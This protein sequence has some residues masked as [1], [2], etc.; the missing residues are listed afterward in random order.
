MWVEL[1]NLLILWLQCWLD[2]QAQ[3]SKFTHDRLFLLK[4]GSLLPKNLKIYSQKW[5]FTPKNLKI[6]SGARWDFHPKQANLTPL[7]LSSQ[8]YSKSGSLLRSHPPKNQKIYSGAGWNFHPKRANLTPLHLVPSLEK[9]LSKHSQF[10]QNSFE[11]TYEMLS[12]KECC[13]ETFF[14]DGR[15]YIVII[16]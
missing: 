9:F 2:F 13:L 4:S 11:Y 16:I 7:P 10:P 1:P 6:Y 5:L 12:F 3:L 14:S 8:I 15:K